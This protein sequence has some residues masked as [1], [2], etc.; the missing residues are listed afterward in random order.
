VGYGEAMRWLGVLIV[1]L[2]VACDEAPKP[3]PSLIAHPESQPPVPPKPEPSPFVGPPAS[4]APA[5]APPPWPEML[6]TPGRYSPQFAADYIASVCAERQ[7][8]DAELTTAKPPPKDAAEAKHRQISEKGRRARLLNKPQLA[9]MSDAQISDV[10]SF[11][12]DM[13][14]APGE[15]ARLLEAHPND[16]HFCI[17][18]ARWFQFRKEKEHAIAEYTRCGSLADASDEASEEIRRYIHTQIAAVKAQH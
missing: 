14:S 7:A 12:P 1:G 16:V 3:T 10:L 5:D 18:H 2:V 13:P 11:N 8:F 15:F 9:D 17:D 6:N 4:E